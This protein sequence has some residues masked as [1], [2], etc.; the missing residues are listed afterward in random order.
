M[1]KASCN[2]SDRVQFMA[3]CGFAGQ[4][5]SVLVR[6]RSVSAVGFRYPMNRVLSVRAIVSD[7]DGA[8]VNRVG[9]EAGTL[10]DRLRLGSLTEDGL[11]YKEKFIVRSYEVGIN[12]TATVETIANLLQEVGC[13]HAQSVGYSTDGFATT[14]TMRKLGLIWV[15]ARMHIEVYKYPA[16]SDVV[17]IETW[18]QGE[19]RVGIRRD[20][21]LK[22][23][24]TDQV[25]GRATSKWLMMNQETRRLQKVSDDVRE[26]V[27]IYCPREPRLA[28]PEEDSNCLKKIPKLEDPG[29]YSRLRLMPRRADLDMNQ[30]V[31]NVTYIGWVLESMPQE[32]IDSH[33]LHSITL[34]YRRECQRDDIVDSLTSIEGDGVL[35]EVNGTN[36]SSIAW[37]HGQA[38]Q[39]FLHLLKLS[40]DEGLEINRGRTAWRKKAS[41]L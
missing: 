3:Q 39:Q 21:I 31:N 40:T 10:A 1:L 25:I 18:C 24:A 33:E 17:E 23:Y 32:I 37:E 8:V 7:R 27:L 20:F 13:N 15:T 30:H 9:A 34:D 5:A 14:P 19:G 41:R 6:R 4:P 38:Y 26:E 28:I 22:D 11:S 29:Q 12:K 35:L 2:G 36:G 16:W